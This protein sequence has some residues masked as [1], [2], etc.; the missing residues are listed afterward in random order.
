MKHLSLVEDKETQEQRARFAE[1]R[2]RFGQF[3]ASWTTSHDI[4]EI[5]RKPEPY[6]RGSGRC[7]TAY[8]NQCEQWE[9]QEARRRKG[10]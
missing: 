5:V 1:L 10:L 9:A 8:I 3:K 2:K 6:L 4:P 7:L